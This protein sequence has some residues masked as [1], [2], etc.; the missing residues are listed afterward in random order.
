MRPTN[1]RA[2]VGSSASGSSAS[3]IVSVPP[4][5]MSA[6]DRVV[7]AAATAAASAATHAATSAS[8]AIRRNETFMA[9]SPWG[10]ESE[11][12]LRGD[13]VT[14]DPSLYPLTCQLDT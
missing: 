8:D 6:D 7:R 2:S 12:G 14:R 11:R 13:T 4:F 5:L 3:P 1:V 10:S 9:P